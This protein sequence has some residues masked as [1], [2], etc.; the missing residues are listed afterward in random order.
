MVLNLEG[1]TKRFGDF[2]AVSDVSFS[3]SKGEIV[4]FLGQNGA[5]KTTTLRMVMDILPVTGGK[6]SLF[7]S[8]DLRKG[9]LRVGF[10]P[11]ERGLYR[12]MKAV[13]TIAYFGRLKGVPGGKAKKKANELLE[14]FGMEQYAQNKIETLSKGNA[15]KIQLL[16]VLTH[17]PE[18][19]ILDEPFSGLDPVNQKLLEDLIHS[20]RQEGATVLF[21]TH[22]MEHAERLC[23]RFVMVKNGEKVFEGTIDEAREAYERRL[24]LTTTDDPSALVGKAGVTGVQ[25]LGRNRFALQ[26]SDGADTQAILAAALQLGITVI[27]FGREEVSLHDI[28]F[29]LAGASQ[30]ATA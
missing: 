2:T 24:I 5:G 4:G 15:Q 6:I 13:D 11:E 10:L 19:L 8:E 20:L 17:E 7:G 27:G 22:T 29:R 28:F 12:K 18:F 3:V 30:E 1:V 26:T 9:R 23:D 14:R 21:S 25:P 16:S